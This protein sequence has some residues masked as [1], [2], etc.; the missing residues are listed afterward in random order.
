MAKATEKSAKKKSNPKPKQNGK[1]KPAAAPEMSEKDVADKIAT[2]RS[3]VRESFGKVVMA[4]MTQ[5]R[6]KHQSL[7]DLTH[8]VLEPLTM[9]RIAMAYGRN[10]DEGAGAPDMAGLAIWASVSEEVDVKI[11][12]QIRAGVFPIRLK[13][14]EWTSG[15]INW[16][17]DV[18]ALD[19]K[20]TGQVIA[21]FRQ[22]VK[23]GELRL[24]P[25]ITKLVDEDT[26]AKMQQSQTDMKEK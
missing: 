20:T 7:A 14:N 5:P 19:Q 16:L 13:P 18:I 6:Y 24:H 17:F 1:T 3:Q 10:A 23:D 2:L 26:L 25:I 4:M 11:R 9:D 21:N 22:V 12:E 15:T 8:L